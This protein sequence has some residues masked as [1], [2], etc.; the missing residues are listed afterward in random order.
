MAR[1][2]GSSNSKVILLSRCTDA[3]CKGF[4][5]QRE[6]RTGQN[7][8]HH[9]LRINSDVTSSTL[10]SSHSHSTFSLSLSSVSVSRSLAPAQCFLVTVHVIPMACLLLF[11][12]T[13]LRV[14]RSSSSSSHAT[15]VTRVHLSA[16]LPLF[17][18]LSFSSSIASLLLSVSWQTLWLPLSLRPAIFSCK[19]ATSQEATG[20]HKGAIERCKERERERER[21]RGKERG[22]EKREQLISLERGKSTQELAKVRE[23]E[24]EAVNATHRKQSLRRTHLHENV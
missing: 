7:L 1:L 17:L 13:C 12:T 16:S 8:P 2:T 15:H 19:L 4:R 9:P 10:H 21:E 20:T 14:H 22:R 11:L 6:A 24:R 3:L 18:S 23:R 5:C